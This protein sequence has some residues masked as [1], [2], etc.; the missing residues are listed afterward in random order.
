LTESALKIAEFF[1]REYLKMSRYVRGRI[2]D[3][4]YRDS[5]DIIQ[6]VFAGIFEAADVSRPIENLGAYIYRAL[7]NRIV[8]LLRSRKTLLSI[9]APGTET[10]PALA[11]IIE[12]PRYDTELDVFNR[13]LNEAL[14]AAIDRLPDDQRAIVIM[15]E[16]E[17]MSY[18][19]ISLKTG[20]PAGTL[21]SRKHR[22]LERI[23]ASL[24]EH[25][26][27]MEK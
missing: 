7:R 14:Y 21:L 16:F 4:S 12:D 15:T 22:A 2:E 6:D 20:I 1:T 8:D 24:Q 11:D 23:R 3:A 9:D 19:E 10:G 26:Y 5:E 25:Y 13:E 27:L 18:R 17:G